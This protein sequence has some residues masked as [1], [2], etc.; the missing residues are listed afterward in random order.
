MR[1]PFSFALVVLAGCGS[2]P[3]VPTSDPVRLE[4]NP[5]VLKLGLGVDTTLQAT[6]NGGESAVSPEAN[7][8]SSD[9]RVARVSSTGIVT[10]VASGR[11]SIWATWKGQYAWADVEVEGRNIIL[12][13]S[14]SPALVAGGQLVITATLVDDNGQEIH[15][16]AFEPRWV[17]LEP[18]IVDATALAGARA[19]LT[20]GAF[21]GRATIWVGFGQLVALLPVDVSTPIPGSDGAELLATY[22]KPV[23]Y[24]WDDAYAPLIRIRAGNSPLE[25]LELA[26][27]DDVHPGRFCL[28]GQ[29]IAPGQTTDFN[30][31]EFSSW[32][33]EI[34]VSP[35]A[36]LTY[37]IGD[38][39]PETYVFPLIIGGGDLPPSTAIQPP[40]SLQLCASQ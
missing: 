29:R 5:K 16:D 10:A 33:N 32:E 27:T 17:A 36:T 39:D 21:P 9:Q 15:S 22:L 40:Y 6:V 7:W 20:A 8:N 3:V 26:I 11:T 34:V 13:S 14:G 24:T 2:N 28:P 12:Q 30:P 31:N 18:R 23:A 35:R 37:R 38:G 4:I 19:R 1:Y 25:V